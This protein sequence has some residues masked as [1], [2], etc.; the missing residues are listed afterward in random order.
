MA[1]FNRSTIMA[2]LESAL[3]EKALLERALLES[4]L[5]KSLLLHSHIRQFQKLNSLLNR[6]QNSRAI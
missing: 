2:L 6:M 4:P 1:L 5:L 3:L